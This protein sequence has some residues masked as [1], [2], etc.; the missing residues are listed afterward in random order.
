MNRST[1][2]VLL[3]CVMLPLVVVA[4]LGVDQQEMPAT[5]QSHVLLVSDPGTPPAWAQSPSSVQSSTNAPPAEAAA[6]GLPGPPSMP[7][8]G[9]ALLTLAGGALAYRRLRNN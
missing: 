8:S 4:G 5:E 3:S 6:P 1:F 9:L 7:L 2:L